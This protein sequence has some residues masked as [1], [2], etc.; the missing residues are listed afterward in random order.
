MMHVYESETELILSGAFIRH[1][2]PGL[3]STPRKASLAA[4][5]DSLE[6]KY[7]GLKDEGIRAFMIAGERFYPADAVDFTLTRQREFYDAYCANFRQPRPAGVIVE[8]FFVGS[9]PCRLY[10]PEAEKNYPVMLYLHGG[11]YVLGG[12]DSHDDVCAE[13]S[14]RADVAVV[15]VQYRLAPDHPFPAAL[16]DAWAVLG[17]LAQRYNRIVIGG[18]SAGGNLSAAIALKARDAGGPKI[19]GQVLIYP[20]LGGDLASG[21]YITQANAPGLT[22]RDVLYYRDVYKGG[23]HKYAE[24]LRETNFNDLPPAFLVAA[25]L[26]PLCDDCENYASKLRQADIPVEVRHEP[27]L[28]HAFLRAR[29]MSEPAAASFSAIVGAT[30][31]FAHSPP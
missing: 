25:A 4:M 8:D 11:G 28:V 22:T 10:R 17:Y 13:L 19:S 14:D 9:I 24:P 1:S 30:R 23:G 20:G 29:H 26:D 18:D 6:I 12:L 2:F 15:G 31:L 27:L 21:S 5:T 7:A 16:D 3:A